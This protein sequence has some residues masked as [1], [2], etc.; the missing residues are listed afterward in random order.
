MY[1][2]RNVRTCDCRNIIILYQGFPNCGV[3]LVICKPLK[4]GTRAALCQE[5][6]GGSSWFSADLEETGNGCLGSER[7]IKCQT[8]PHWL[9]LPCTKRGAA[10]VFGQKGGLKRVCIRRKGSRAAAAHPCP[11]GSQLVFSVALWL[12]HSYKRTTQS[13]S[14]LPQAVWYSKTAHFLGYL[15]YEMLLYQSRRSLSGAD[16]FPTWLSLAVAPL[17][18]CCW[19]F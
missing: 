15:S 4:S 6:G 1:Y 5:H 14:P 19:C 11:Q 2:L 13:P 7:C 16:P 18:T 17:A 3:P 9:F 12:M 10:A 8:L